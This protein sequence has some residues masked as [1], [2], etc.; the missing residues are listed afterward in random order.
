MGMCICVC[1]CV[2]VCVYVLIQKKVLQNSVHLLC[3]QLKVTEISVVTL[4]NNY[5]LFFFIVSVY[6]IYNETFFDVKEKKVI[7]G[8]QK[9]ARVCQLCLMQ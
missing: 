1:V 2:C 9:K 8:K 7:F 5:L 4:F 6:Y 3:G